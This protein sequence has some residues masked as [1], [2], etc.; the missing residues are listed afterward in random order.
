MA[1]GANPPSVVISPVSGRDG[2]EKDTLRNIRETEE[3][4]VSIVTYPMRERMNQTSFE[5]P[6][7]VSEW[8]EAPFVPAPATIV[9]P[10]RVAESPMA[11]ECRLFQ[12]VPHGN[13]GLSANY[14]IGEVVAFHVAEEMLIEGDVLPDTEKVGYI[15]R[16]GAEWYTHVTEESLFALPRPTR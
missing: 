14:I 7:G 9:K 10:P 12:I 8:E 11:M 13:G 1:G 4:T 6:H 3:Y 15:A 2:A 5:Y 16:L